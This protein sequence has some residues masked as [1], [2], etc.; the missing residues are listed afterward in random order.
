MDAPYLVTW[1]PFLKP[2][3]DCTD[4]WHRRS[5]P[6]WDSLSDVCTH[7]SRPDS[8]CVF[9]WRCR[10]TTKNI[11]QFQSGHLLLVLPIQD[12]QATIN[13]LP[14]GTLATFFLTAVGPIQH[15]K[16]DDI[17]RGKT[18]LMTSLRLERA[19]AERRRQLSISPLPFT[20]RSQSEQSHVITLVRA[21]RAAALRRRW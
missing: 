2:V 17:G 14:W 9:S 12:S 8:W 11:C 3:S 5:S 15:T 19:D 13:T 1:W 21:D 18:I 4:S 7:I 6:D 10:H 20:C 16:E